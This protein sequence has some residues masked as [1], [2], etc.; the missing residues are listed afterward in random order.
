MRD[1]LSMLSGPGV[2]SQQ[3]DVGQA[4]LADIGDLYDFS[5]IFR[6]PEQAERFATP[7][8]NAEI[9]RLLRELGVA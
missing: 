2:L 9:E 6:T 3:V 1:L 5:S 8:D 4:E 7:Y